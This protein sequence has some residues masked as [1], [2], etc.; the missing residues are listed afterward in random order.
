MG[1]H[2]FFSIVCVFL[3]FF[4]F[5]RVV[6]LFLCFVFFWGVASFT[7]LGVLGACFFF[8]VLRCIP[9]DHF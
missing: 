1:F 8:W 9:D 7:S 5:I 4:F 6:V 3:F 2:G